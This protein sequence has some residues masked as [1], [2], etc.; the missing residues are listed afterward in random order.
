MYILYTKIM[1][2]TIIILLSIDNLLHTTII[3]CPTETVL[4]HRRRNIFILPLIIKKK[5]K[6]NKSMQ[7]RRRAY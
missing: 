7:H 3:Y 6:L 4:G 2:M 5:Y 1:M